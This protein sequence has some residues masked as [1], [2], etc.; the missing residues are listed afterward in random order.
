MSC[1]CFEY[2]FQDNSSRS[3]DK[4]TQKLLFAFWKMQGGFERQDRFQKH[5]KGF[6]MQE[7]FRKDVGKVLKLCERFYCREKVGK[8]SKFQERL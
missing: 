4:K 1:M 6:K 8:V 3:I 7:R 5:K 2:I